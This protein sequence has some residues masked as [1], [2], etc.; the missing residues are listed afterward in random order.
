MRHDNF[1]PHDMQDGLSNLGE[2]TDK[3]NEKIGV[4]SQNYEGLFRTLEKSSDSAV[5][6][7]MRGTETWQQ[8][9]IH[10]LGNL[11]IK[12]AQTAFNDV[13]NFAKNQASKLLISQTT[14]S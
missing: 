1:N 12:F 6:N 5:K 7:I 2:S 3:V 9:M 8:A 11:E 13:L 4:L 10:V 14:N